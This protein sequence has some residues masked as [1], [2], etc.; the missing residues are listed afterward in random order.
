MA[1]VKLPL[2]MANGVMVRTIEELRENFDIKKVVGYFL[3]GKL[4]NWLEARYYEEEF[5]MVNDLSESDPELVKKLCEIFGV[6]YSDEKFDVEVI[7][8]ENERLLKLKQYT[9]DE[10]I[11]ANIDRVAFNQEELDTLCNKEYDNIYLC[12]DL[13]LISLSEKNTKYIG[14]NRPTVTFSSDIETG[15]FLNDMFKN[16][17][18]DETSNFLNSA[19]ELKKAENLYLNNEIDKA[20]EIFLKLTEF[21][22][23]RAMYYLG[24]ILANGYGSIKKDKE[25][26]ND[27]RYKGYLCKDILSSINYAFTLSDKKT[28]ENIINQYFNSLVELSCDNVVAKYELASLYCNSKYIKSDMVKF[29]DLLQECVNEGFWLAMNRLGNAYYNGDDIQQNYPKAFEYYKMAAD[30]NYGLAEF[31]IGKCYNNGQ[32][33]EKDQEKSIEWYK[34][35]ALHGIGEAANKVGLAYYNGTGVEKDKE[36][37]N[38]WFKMGADIGNAYA[39][40]NYALNCRDGWG[41]P[42]NNIEA[43]YYFEMAAK[44]DHDSA[45][46]ALGIM[47]LEGIGVEQDFDNAVKWFKKSAELG[48]SDS[49][50]RLGVRYAKGQGVEQNQTQEFYWFTKAAS[51]NH[52][53]AIQNLKN[54][55]NFG[56][57]EIFLTARDGLAYSYKAVNTPSF[58][59]VFELYIWDS[60]LNKKKIYSGTYEFSSFAREVLFVQN[61]KGLVVSFA[62]PCE[63]AVIFSI[64]EYNVEQLYSWKIS[65]G[66]GVYMEMVDNKIDIFEKIVENK[67][68]LTTITI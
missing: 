38:Y 68:H 51:Q 16:V 55:C 13:F 7:Q 63:I 25:K 39:Q 30:K 45:Q 5:E 47:Y 3:D 46:N 61:E 57:N 53:K 66:A 48:N 35:A 10:E 21:N 58:D 19:N 29:I 17:K 11:I 24:E 34:K 22:N 28:A 52:E 18:F 37:E 67:K 60:S 27:W 4:N 6:D 65:A 43:H 42:I 54:L 31:N 26:A 20:Y 15:Q 36:Q 40:Y 50:N 33:V 59:S 12:G 14:I 9:D 32:G 1:K 56:E 8:E 62:I 23:G 41:M 64:N 44:Q 49:Q 2:E